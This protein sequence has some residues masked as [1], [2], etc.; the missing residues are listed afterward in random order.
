MNSSTASTSPATWVGIIDAMFMLDPDKPRVGLCVDAP[1]HPCVIMRTFDVVAIDPEVESI[2]IGLHIPIA[3][4]VFD[5][6]TDRK[7]VEGRGERAE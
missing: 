2:A 7:T 4:A 6:G 3:F 1:Q 5:N